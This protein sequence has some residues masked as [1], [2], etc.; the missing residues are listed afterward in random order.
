MYWSW[1]SL[2]SSALK[3]SIALGFHILLLQIWDIYP[4]P[5]FPELCVYSPQLLP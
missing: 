5:L 1:W 2:I 3:S 4:V